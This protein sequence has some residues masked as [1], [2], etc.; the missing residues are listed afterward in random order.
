MQTWSPPSPTAPSG[1][2]ST[3]SRP[4]GASSSWS[5]W[6]SSRKPKAASWPLRRPT[7]LDHCSRS[8][9]MART[10]PWMWSTPPWTASRE[11]PSRMR[12]WPPDTG[13][14][15]RCSFKTTGCSFTSAVRTS[16]CQSWTC[17]SKRCCPRRWRTSPG[18]GSQREQEK[19]D[20]W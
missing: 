12:T 15:S 5:T 16:T 1:T 13:R 6:S 2:S 20:L 9:P 8:F 3:P 14:T 17:Q 18:S 10:T 7:D 4:R 19:T 11:C